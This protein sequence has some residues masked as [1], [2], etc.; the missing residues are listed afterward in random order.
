MVEHL[1]STKS[2]TEPRALSQFVA[3]ISQSLSTP[4]W[5]QLDSMW[6]RNKM[7]RF[8]ISLLRPSPRVVIPLAHVITLTWVAM[9]NL[10]E[11]LRH[12]VFSYVALYSAIFCCHGRRGEYILGEDQWS[13]A[14][15]RTTYTAKHWHS[16]TVE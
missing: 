3:L 5:P 14:P 7:E 9:P 1:F 15:T 12:G 8:M 13:V 11:R 2:Y 6:K 4:A 10:Q 16:L